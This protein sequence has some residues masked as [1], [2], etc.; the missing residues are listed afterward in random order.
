MKKTYL[1]IPATILSLVIIFLLYKYITRPEPDSCDTIFQQTAVQLTSSLQILKQT[2]EISVGEKKIQDLTEAAQIVAL[3]LKT[4]C[5]M[6]MKHQISSEDFLKCQQIG[7]KYNQQVN[8]LANNVNIIEQAKRKGDSSS[9]NQ[10]LT[11][12]DLQLSNLQQTVTFIKDKIQP[13]SF[14]PTLE[15]RI[16][17][18]NVKFGGHIFIA[19]D[20]DWAQTID[21]NE[22]AAV[23]KNPGEVVYGFKDGRK[24]TFDM[25]CMLIPDQGDNVKEFELYYGNDSPTGRFDSIGHFTTQNARLFDTPY[26]QFKFSSVTAKYIKI[27]IISFWMYG[28]GWLHKFQLWGILK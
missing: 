17:L 15:G 2:G 18:I 14:T 1:V 21:T 12:V 22:S 5:I 16:N 10:T 26:Q 13:A 6:N 9:V 20:Q 25:F 27:K 28:Y 7:D 3:N 23:D 24:A 19:P 11:T 4:C 8:D